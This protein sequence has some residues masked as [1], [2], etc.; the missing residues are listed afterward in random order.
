VT[1][2]PGHIK[3]DPET[4]AVAVR[5]AFPDDASFRGMAWLIATTNVG[6]R[7]TTTTEVDT[8]DDLYTPQ[9]GS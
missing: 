6:A 7:N 8:W 9:E 1:Y 5:T 2:Q 4:G 3:R